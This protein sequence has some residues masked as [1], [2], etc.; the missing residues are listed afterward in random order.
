[1]LTV[2]WTI[3]SF[4][5][6]SLPF[7]VWIGR[8]FLKTDIR[9]Y[10]DHNPG[11][12]NV[13]RAGGGLLGGLAAALDIS[14]GAVPIGLA[15]YWLGLDGWSLVPVSLAPIL[16][17]AFSPFLKFKGGKAIAVTGG[18]WL[19]LLGLQG[20]G[21][22]L[23]LFLMWYA[24][25]TNDGWIVILALASLLIYLLLAGYGAPMVVVWLGNSLVIAWKHRG[26]LTQTP[27]LRGWL[28]KTERLT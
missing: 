9:R 20:F 5:S 27:R 18:V 26:D 17:H 11:A 6:G 21:V 8:L 10:G 24:L 25:V 1:M 4:I 13:T 19:G 22:I 28:R 14:K 15:W 23:V 12:T 2:V 7:S 3:I 16:G